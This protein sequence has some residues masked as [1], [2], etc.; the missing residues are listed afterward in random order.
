MNSTGPKRRYVRASDRRLAEVAAQAAARIDLKALQYRRSASTGIMTERSIDGT[1]IT[2]TSVIECSLAEM[3]GLLASP[4]SDRYAC[5]MRELVGHDFIYGAIVHHAEK[6]TTQNITVRTAT[7]LKRHMLAHN[8]QWCHVSALKTLEA[9]SKDQVQGFT[10]SLASLHP[11]DVFTGKAQAASVTNI[12][13]LSVLYLVTAEPHGLIKGRRKKRAVRVTFCA[14]VATTLGYSRPS[15]FRWFK[16]ARN[17]EEASDASNGAVLARAVQLARTLNHLHV[18]VRRH[19]L[20]AQVLV[21]LQKVQPNNSRCAC[22]TR[23]ISVVKNIFGISKGEKTSS[24]SSKRCQLCGFLV[25]ARCVCTIGKESLSGMSEPL[26]N[27]TK[28]SQVVCLCEHCMQRVDDADYDNYCTSSSSLS[29][30]SVQPDSPNTEPASV[31]IARALSQ[32]LGSASQEDK[33]AVIRVIKHLLSLNHQKEHNKFR[34]DSAE[35]AKSLGQ[36]AEKQGFLAGIPK[37]KTKQVPEVTPGGSS[38]PEVCDVPPVAGATGRQYALQYADLGDSN[39]AVEDAEDTEDA[40]DA[41]EEVISLARHPV[42]ADEARRLQW[43]N[44]H[45]NIISSMMNLPDLMVLCNIARSE[46]QC[47]TTLVT[48]VGPSV[49]HVVA[50]TNPVWIGSQTPRDHSLCT[51]ALMN[52][53]PLFVRH[54]EADVRFSAMN[55]V[56]RG[57]IR[58]YFA[59]P[60]RIMCP[61]GGGSTAIGTFCCISA[62]ESRNVSEPQ[63]ALMATLAD[64]ASRVMETLAEELR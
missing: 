63:Y 53:A 23:R 32:L 56:R 52:G 64:G 37:S 40:G 41:G 33:P 24:Q 28:H 20:D 39:A 49:V 12:R 59:F 54:P 16:L 8:E 46:L 61:N 55:A 21:D 62:G 13:G 15:P 58:F 43:I 45:P 9:F 1:V 17:G 44:S 14:H 5:V 18:A 42:P 10:V 38:S 25:C 48:I 27:G 6:T 60:I 11:D 2:S 7:F 29:P 22:C 30:V 35:L 47:D 26:N 31:V 57:D 50:S 51:H 4:T 19:R 3:R 36:L 34:A